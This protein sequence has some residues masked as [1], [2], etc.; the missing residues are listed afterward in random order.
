MNGKKTM[1]GPIRDELGI[2]QGGKFSCEFYKIYNSEQLTVPQETELGTFI[3]DVHIASIGQADDTVLVSNDLY[4][5]KFL[6]HLTLQYCSKYNVELSSSKTKLQVFTPNK[7]P[8]SHV[9]LITN[10]AHPIIDDSPIQFV[11]TTEHVGIVRSTDGNLP[12]ILNRMTAHNR[13]LH[14][15]LAVGLARSHRANPAASLHVEKLY[16]VPVLLSG[17]ASLVLKSSDEDTLNHH[18]KTKIQQL[19]K[20]YDRTPEEVVYFLAGTLPAEA[21]LH[22]RQLSLFNMITRLPDNIQNRIAHY[23][24]ITSRDRD[25]SWFTT[26]AKLSY[27][28]DL[29]HPLA[30]LENPLSKETS[31]N[32]IKSKVLDYWQT[33][34]RLSASELSSLKYFKTEFMSL[35]QTH[36]IW[37]TCGN[38]SYEVTKAVVQ[39]RF[40][41][42]RYRT[43]ALSSHF[44][45]NNSPLCSI[46]PEEIIGSIEHI[47]TGCRALKDTRT[48]LIKALNHNV[49]YSIETKTIILQYLSTSIEHMTQFL[50]DPSV[51]PETIHEVQRQK[52]NVLS[53]LF[54]FTRSWCYAMHLK[55][56][57]L[58]GRTVK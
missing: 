19:Q 37:T 16:G 17:T 48:K 49:Y 6:L 22:I 7:T 25:R 52:K 58:Q 33:K 35:R 46:C 56:L 14:S 1:M 10:S 44:S 18:F 9:K 51:I 24:L 40:L 20:L 41:S 26:I 13:A 45:P 29:P 8:S 39:A 38:N 32:L 3:G 28:Y 4:K 34:F 43:E 47:L 11:N 31:K 50:V 21:T 12:H 54:H 55:R 42:G 23:K 2:E 30:L 36:P 5:L 15:I 57:Q 27:M 53:E